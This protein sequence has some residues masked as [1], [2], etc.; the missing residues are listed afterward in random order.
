[1]SQTVADAARAEVD[2]TAAVSNAY[3]LA[4]WADVLVSS[5][6]QWWKAHP[7]AKFHPGMKYC[8]FKG[9]EGVSPVP[10]DGPIMLGSN[11]GLLAMA[12]AVSLG[13]RELHLHGFD[14][15]GSHFFGWHKEPGLKNTPDHRFEVF[16]RQFERYQ[17]RGITIYNR[18][19]GSALKCYEF[20]PL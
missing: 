14:M 8:S 12:V 19:P 13:A 2:H 7:S 6:S 4:R 1:M 10:M 20:K 5:D 17:P 3:V 11:S 15:H 18:T 9:V 16:K